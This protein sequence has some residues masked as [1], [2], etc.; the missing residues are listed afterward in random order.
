MPGPNRGNQSN[1]HQFEHFWKTDLITLCQDPNR[2]NQ[3]GKYIEMN[4]FG[5]YTWNSTLKY[6]YN[7]NLNDKTI[8][9]LMKAMY[10]MTKEGGLTLFTNFRDLKSKISFSQ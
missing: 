5:F 10:K 8:T 7:T 2:G 1:M 9:Q 3:I 4:L 6:E